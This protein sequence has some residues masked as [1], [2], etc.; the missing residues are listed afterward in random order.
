M[1]SVATVSPLRFTSTPRI[2]PFSVGPP[3]WYS[4]FITVPARERDSCRM[5]DVAVDEHL[6]RAH[7]RDFND[8]VRRRV[9]SSSD[10]RVHTAEAAVE[11]R[12]RV[13]CE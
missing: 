1:S 8:E 10:A 9:G 7:R 13:A 12:P 5:R 4:A 2:E 6:V 11:R 3:A